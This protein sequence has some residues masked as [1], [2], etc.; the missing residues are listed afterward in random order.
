M[1]HPG[2]DPLLG[3]KHDVSFGQLAQQR[4]IGTAAILSSPSIGRQ[5]PFG[6]LYFGTFAVRRRAGAKGQRLFGVGNRQLAGQCQS[7]G[8]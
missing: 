1:D 8:A 3:I 2:H 7:G 6:D 5:A 4:L